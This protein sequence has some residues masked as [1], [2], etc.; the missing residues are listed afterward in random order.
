VKM[1]TQ[2]AGESASSKAAGLIGMQITSSFS[3]GGHG[4]H[5]H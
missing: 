2:M 3:L 5:I 4:A 1:Q